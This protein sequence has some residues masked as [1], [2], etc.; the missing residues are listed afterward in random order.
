MG[1]PGLLEQ[2]WATLRIG[3]LVDVQAEL[4]LYDN[5]HQRHLC[6]SVIHKRFFLVRGTIKKTPWVS[7]L[8]AEVIQGQ[9]KPLMDISRAY[10]LQHEVPSE[11]SFKA[12]VE[13]CAGMSIMSQGIESCEHH[14]KVSNELRPAYCRIIEMTGRSV[15]VCG[16]IGDPETIAHMHA[17]WSS[18]ST[19]LAGFS[20]QPWSRLGDQKGL[21]DQRSNSLPATLKAA[22]H[23]R[24]HTII[25]ECVTS[26]GADKGVKEIL[27]TFMKETG[28]RM[29][30][31][32]VTL[33]HIMPA[34]RQR[35]W[36]VMT[37]PFLP[38]IQ[39]R[40]DLPEHVSG[41][42]FQCSQIGQNPR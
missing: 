14:V 40:R 21:G 15:P 18:S 6:K 11:E 19:M 8:G 24:C 38:P 22:F 30:D 1:S 4:V 41:I 32:T 26:A 36:C 29:G 39:R 12:V 34:N 33:E 5:E 31:T 42:S 16:D 23:L 7:F 37:S 28:Y 17:H 25:L 35:W 13:T 20:C 27:K 9:H 10:V 3:D 2:Q